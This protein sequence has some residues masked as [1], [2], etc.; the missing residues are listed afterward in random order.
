MLVLQQALYKGNTI[1]LNLCVLA[2]QLF[3]TSLNNSYTPVSTTSKEITQQ[4]PSSVRPGEIAP[5]NSPVQSPSRVPTKP[6]LGVMSGGEKQASS[7]WQE[8]LKRK[9]PGFCSARPLASMLTS[10]EKCREVHINPPIYE[11][12]SDRRGK[13][14]VTRVFCIAANE[15]FPYSEPDL[16]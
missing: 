12:F 9:A 13:Q 5:P 15:R 4:D 7:T 6:G 1:C 10:I 8:K 11:T 3:E 14:V 16:V 2:I